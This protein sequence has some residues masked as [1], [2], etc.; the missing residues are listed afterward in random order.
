MS[1]RRL[2][3]CRPETASDSSD[4]DQILREQAGAKET[5]SKFALSLSPIDEISWAMAVKQE[6]KG[7]DLTISSPQQ[8]L[9]GTRPAIC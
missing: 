3:L 9:I 2:R 6:T 5:K 4:A 7:G 8:S 1:R